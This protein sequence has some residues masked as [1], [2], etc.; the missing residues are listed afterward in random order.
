M[1]ELLVKMAGNVLVKVKILK[2][3]A[4]PMLIIT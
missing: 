1:E 2:H 3:D 4:H